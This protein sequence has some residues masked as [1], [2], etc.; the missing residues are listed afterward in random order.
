MVITT[1]RS[2]KIIMHTRYNHILFE[3]PSLRL[4]KFSQTGKF[5]QS[6]YLLKIFSVLFPL[7]FFI[8]SFANAKKIIVDANGKGDFKTI[9]GAINSLPEH[10]AVDRV[11]F[12]KKGVYNEK[13]YIEKSHIVLEGEDK[14]T[15]IIMV[16]I[17]R[18]EWRC[19]HSD[20]WGVATISMSGNDITLKNLTISNTYGFDNANKPDRIIACK[21]DTVTQQKKITH[22]GH[23]MAL[24]TF[25][26]TRLKVINCILK[27]F[28]GD[29]V[30]PWNVT[31]GMFYFKDCQMEGG[32]D[33]YCPRGWA[34]AVNC[35]FKANTGDAAIWHDGSANPE[36]KTVLK[37]CRF[38]GYDGFKLGRYHKDAQFYLIDC[39]FADNMTDKPIYRASSPQSLKWGERVY[40]YNCHKKNG[41]DFSW[42]TNNIPADKAGL[43]NA[44]WTFDGKWDAV[45]N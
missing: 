10:S 12:I 13:L 14:A 9:Q 45:E 35:D 20:D 43:I 8:T 16:A 38:T 24:R 7:L 6:S 21:A 27:A 19:D 22:T 36:S 5:R 33:F 37:N 30:S 18:D 44:N 26:T 29:T 2:E 3:M 41:R 31:D 1:I 17:A 23:Q 4:Q 34:Y 15:T 25:Q 32:V 42:Y 40:Y 39:V 11:I 28:A